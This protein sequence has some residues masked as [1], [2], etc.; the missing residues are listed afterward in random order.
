M[1]RSKR[2]CCACCAAAR[3]PGSRGSARK[4][5]A[6]W[7]ARYCPSPGCSSSST[8]P[9]ANCRR[10]MILRT[11]IRATCARGC[12]PP[13]CPTS[14]SASARA[15][16]TSCWRLQDM[17]H[18]TAAPGIASSNLCRSWHLRC[19]GKAL[20]LPAL[21]WAAMITHCRSRCCAR[22]PAV[23]DCRSG[24]LG[25]VTSSLSPAALRDA[26]CRSGMVGPPKSASIGCG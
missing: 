7:C 24:P 25:R 11:A 19:R 6:A 12:A 21:R 4:G 5:V 10:T 3:R 17:P 18:A 22:P 9:R 14:R 16:K 8:P 13:C 20:P 2:C 15:F 1:I 26:A 23:R